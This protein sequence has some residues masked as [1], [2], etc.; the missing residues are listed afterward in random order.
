MATSN[1][2][3]LWTPANKV[4]LAR[5]LL[6]PLFVL[7]LVAPWP[8][9]F[10]ASMQLD[11]A[12]PWIAAIVFIILSMTDMLDGYLARSRGEVT[13]FGKFMDPLADK[14]LVTAALL[15]LIELGVIPS[16]VALI[17]I[18]R[19][20]IVS[21][22]RMVAASKGEV[23]AASWY[24]KVKTVFQM[25]AIVLFIIKDSDFIYVS[26]SLRA[27]WLFIFSWLIMVI[28]LVMTIVSMI[29]YLYKARHLIGFR[30]K[31]SQGAE[32][33][34]LPLS[35][36]MSLSNL[37]EEVIGLAREH[38]VTLATAESCT[39]GLIASELTSIAGSSDVYL[40][41]VVSYANEVK[42]GL[43]GVSGESLA[44]VGA[45]S[46][47]VACQMALGARKSTGADFAVSVTGIAGPGGGT[48]EKPVGTVWI[49]LAGPEGVQAQR[50]VF[51]GDRSEVRAQTVEESLKALGEALGANSIS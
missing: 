50:F 41:S 36:Q 30:K 22:V 25:I 47:E 31:G 32:I 51:D 5:I 26:S 13:D 37:A 39:G 29:D 10:P 15:G 38:G 12:K 43:L 28:A 46:E 6:I 8:A 11:M 16:W 27:D 49:G 35:E 20:F 21:G 14:L 23:I 48:P 42:E 17:I 19:E 1:E 33:D 34:V 24:G 4:T 3:E 40:G 45:V 7:V 18:S 2:Q 9:A 44:T